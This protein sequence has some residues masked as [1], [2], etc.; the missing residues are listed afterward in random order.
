MG[1]FTT[2]GQGFLQDSGRP[3][4]L[5]LSDGRDRVRSLFLCSRT[6]G[7]HLGRHL[8]RISFRPPGYQYPD[9]ERLPPSS[10]RF[11]LRPFAFFF[12]LLVSSVQSTCLRLLYYT[13]EF[14]GVRCKP[15]PPPYL[16]LTLVNREDPARHSHEYDSSPP[17]DLSRSTRFCRP[18]SRL[19][20]TGPSWVRSGSGRRSTPSRQ[21]PRFR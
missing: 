20:G 19:R 9:T 1:P 15:L 10:P 17:K 7:N 12:S 8:T 16:R 4:P 11:M 5:V 3:G 18:D 13:C 2:G 21:D 14:H 6:P